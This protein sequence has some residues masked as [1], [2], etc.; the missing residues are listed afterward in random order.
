MEC[1][2]APPSRPDDSARPMREIL[3]NLPGQCAD[4]LIRS[5][6]L[7][8]FSARSILFRKG[9]PAEG[10][11]WVQRGLVKASV[12][13]PSGEERLVTV[14]GPGDI[15]GELAMIDGLPRFATVASITDCQVSFVDAAT[16]QAC[17]QTYPEL[18]HCIALTLAHRLREAQE[19]VA[20]SFLPSSARVAR[21]LLKLMKLVGKP[22]DDDRVGIPYQIKHDALAMA[23]GVARE[24]ASRVVAAWR[25]RHIVS[26]TSKYP[27][28]V[29]K[30]NL[31]H[32]QKAAS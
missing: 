32:E 3:S 31:Q 8:T 26:R 6:K 27:L 28:V 20:A 4:R 22:I 13:S 23:A 5:A 30:T 2:A 1:M 18:Q 17:Q 21:A 19:D 16:F 9:D 12:L 25:S 11:Y 15:V 7:F 14:Y 24:S 29:H 10:C